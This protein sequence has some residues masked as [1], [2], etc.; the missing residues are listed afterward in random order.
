M[1]PLSPDN[2]PRFRVHY[3][4][5]GHQ[6]D[7]QLRSHDSPSF[8]GGFLTNFLGALTGLT[9][10]SVLDFVDFATA[11]SSVYNPVTTGVEG[12][13]WGVGPGSTI[14]VP[15]FVNFIG[16]TSGGRRVRVAVFGMGV[17]SV[18][19]RWQAGENA[20]I[21]NAIAELVTMG[22]HLRGIDDLTPIWKS[23]AN[24]GFNAY[25]QKAVRP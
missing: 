15:E 12:M 7:F 4:V 23:Y 24:A 16:R 13:T 10:A 2:T 6:H 25:W 14:Q 17:D 21:D 11:G 3:T 8:I 19:Y 20:G 5:S 18:D 22:S 1:A 9:F